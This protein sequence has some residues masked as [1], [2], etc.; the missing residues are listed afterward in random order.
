MSETPGS[1]KNPVLQFFA[2]L[3]A[4]NWIAILGAAL[5]VIFILQN[6]QRVRIEFLFLD[7]NAPLRIS[8]GAVLLI[9]WVVGRF[10]F[11]KR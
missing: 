8:L 10:S 4:K 3:S 2:R 1:T 9:G 7:L 6:R 5:A 11:R